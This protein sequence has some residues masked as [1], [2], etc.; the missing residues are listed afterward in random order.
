M[1]DGYIDEGECP[2]CQAH[3]KFRRYGHQLCSEC[4]NKIYVE[5]GIGGDGI[6]KRSFDDEIKRI[7]NYTREL[8]A[9]LTDVA[10]AGSNLARGAVGEINRLTAK[11]I[12]LADLRRQSS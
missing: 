9:F 1:A 4:G 6:W 12:Y 7:D 3:L 10:I 8:N 5:P 11:K 2:W